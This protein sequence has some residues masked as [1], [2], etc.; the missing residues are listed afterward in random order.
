[1][2]VV[3]VVVVVEE[4]LLVLFA[5]VEIAWVTNSFVARV[6]LALSPVDLGALLVFNVCVFLVGSVFVRL[7]VGNTFCLDDVA[8]KYCDSFD[9]KYCEL[10]KFT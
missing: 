9:L 3:G 8:A 10:G 1:M 2:V 6:V 4:I 5:D 7:C